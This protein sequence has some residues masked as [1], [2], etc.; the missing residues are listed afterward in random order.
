ME[1]RKEVYKDFEGKHILIITHS[2]FKY[3]TCNLRVLDSGVSFTD[4][5]NQMIFLDINDIK[6]IQEVVS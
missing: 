1:E 2:N 6:F 5:R 3:H 4:N